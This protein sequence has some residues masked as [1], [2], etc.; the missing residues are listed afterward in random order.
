[1][2]LFRRI[3]QLFDKPQ[4]QAIVLF[5]Y[6]LA[7]QSATE[8]ERKDQGGLGF[9]SAVAREKMREKIDGEKKAYIERTRDV[10]KRYKQDV[11]GLVEEA[12]KVK[13]SSL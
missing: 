3:F 2:T 6:V 11:Q 12:K 7:M 8:A 9:L 1:M 4:D 10:L 5:F 13:K